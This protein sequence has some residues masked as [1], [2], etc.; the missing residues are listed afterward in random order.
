[1]KESSNEELLG[2]VN[3]RKGHN[4]LNPPKGTSTSHAISTPATAKE[5]QEEFLWPKKNL[6]FPKNNLSTAGT[7]LLAFCTECQLTLN[8]LIS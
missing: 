5:A 1:M 2:V 4:N 7:Q 6:K 3:N 8:D